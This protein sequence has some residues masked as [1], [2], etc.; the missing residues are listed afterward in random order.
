MVAQG[1][2]VRICHCCGSP[3]QDALSHEAAVVLGE[4][5][6][7]MSEIR[8]QIEPQPEATTIIDNVRKLS[9]RLRAAADSMAV[10][11]DIMSDNP[12]DLISDWIASNRSLAEQLLAVTVETKTLVF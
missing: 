12:D 1:R 2:S 6:G 7:L 5:R 8:Q 3:V 11:R 10:S 9:A 4:L